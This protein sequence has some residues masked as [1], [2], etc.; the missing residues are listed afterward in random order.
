M[1]DESINSDGQTRHLVPE[2][3]PDAI[4]GGTG[5]LDYSMPWVIKMRVVG[6]PDVIQIEVREQIILGR[7]DRKS[8]VMP[9]VDLNP[10]Q[11]HLHGV[12]RN[13][14]KISARNSRI[15]IR[16]LGSANGTFLNEGRLK[17]DV[18]YRLRHGDRLML[19]KL[20]LQVMFVVMP[21][22]YEKYE[23]QYN[24]VDIVKIGS[25]Q[26]VLLVD[27]DEKVAGIISSVLKQ[28]GFEI[29]IAYSGSEA[30]TL[31]EKRNPSVVLLE[32][33]L[34]D[35]GGME[36]VHFIRERDPDRTVPI[37]VMSGATGG[38]QSGQAVSAGADIFLSKPVGV[39][40]LMQSFGELV[41]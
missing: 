15:T 14:A 30:L 4:P 22:S 5:P 23:T 32:L 25:G 3:L 29:I 35:M 24:D 8:P 36:V 37:I 28:A 17:P 20:T 26:R 10:F 1:S 27:D 41:R 9:D 19:G 38:Y 33:L 34:P 40:E 13:H 18:E 39:D 11:A 6:T 12:S 31:F 2:N 7:S 16:D 21:S